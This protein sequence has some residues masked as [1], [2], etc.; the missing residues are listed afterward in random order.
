MLTTA[1]LRLSPVVEDD[2]EELFALHADP[3]AF[4]EDLT[5][6]LT[7]RA[8]MRWVLGQWIEGWARHGLG[9]LTVRAR[10]PA[11]GTRDP[12]GT[13]AAHGTGDAD[14]AEAPDS[15]PSGLLGVV[16]LTPF[17]AAGPHVLSAY[18]RLSPAATGRGVASEAMR[19]VLEH[20]S[21]G[22]RGDEVVA[23]TA[24]GN[25]PSRALA[26]RLGFVPA[27]PDRAVPGERDGDVLLARPA[28]PERAAPDADGAGR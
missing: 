4:A 19:A 3:R 27:P 17:E 28:S 9:Y 14:G 20:P 24:A 21:L 12:D 13:R 25:H 11:G 23:V 16:G 2:L 22:G 18:W 10:T 1:R 6:P 15:L 5:E 26:A 7:D 8:Q